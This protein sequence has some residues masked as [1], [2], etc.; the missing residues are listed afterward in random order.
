MEGRRFSK[1]EYMRTVF[2]VRRLIN[3]V[4][5]DWSRY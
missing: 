5:A 2:D 1:F 4:S 3:S